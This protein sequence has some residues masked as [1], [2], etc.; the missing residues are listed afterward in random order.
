MCV[1]FFCIFFSFSSRLGRSRLRGSGKAGHAKNLR[2]V[3]CFRIVFAF[4]AFSLR[5]FCIFLAFFLHVLCVFF[6]SGA[7][8]ARTGSEKAGN[9]KILRGVACF[10]HVLCVFFPCSLR[11]FFALPFLCFFFA[12]GAPEARRGSGKTGHTKKLG[13]VAFVFA[14]SLLLLLHFICVFLHVLCVVLSLSLRLLR[15]FLCRCT[16]PAQVVGLFQKQRPPQNANKRDTGMQNNA[17]QMQNQDAKT[18]QN[19][20]IRNAKYLFRGFLVCAEQN[21][22][23]VGDHSCSNF[24]ASAVWL[25]NPHIPCSSCTL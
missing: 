7:P 20:R 10:L 1:A 12:S 3:A 13:G 19:K 2:G 23:K 15:V 17:K 4:F 5:C 6:A 9:V 21:S 8:E 22:Y 24:L 14:C 11:W 16:A 25:V 18:M